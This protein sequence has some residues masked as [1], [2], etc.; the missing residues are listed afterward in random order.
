MSNSLQCHGLQPTR[1]LCPRD[2]PGKNTGVGC[3]FLLQG[4]LLTQDLNL[5]LLHLLHEQPDAP[6]RHLSNTQDSVYGPRQLVTCITSFTPCSGTGITNLPN[7]GHK[8]TRAHR[9]ATC[10]GPPT[11]THTLRQRDSEVHTPTHTVH[12]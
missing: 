3:H 1:I 10:P 5:N 2:F 12:L 6:P 11:Q 4:I 7:L 8:E 9:P